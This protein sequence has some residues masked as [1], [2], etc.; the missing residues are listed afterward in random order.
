MMLTSKLQIRTYTPV[1]HP[2]DGPLPVLRVCRHLPRRHR[3]H[4]R[5][6]DLVIPARRIRGATPQ[7]GVHPLPTR[8]RLRDG[9]QVLYIR[10]KTVR[11]ESVRILI[12]RFRNVEYHVF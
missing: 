2:A 12:V 9:P 7:P 11:I 8:G 5:G 10:R 3:R 4:H 6:Q 1:L